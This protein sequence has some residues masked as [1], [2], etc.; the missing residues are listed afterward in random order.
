MFI[1]Y[2][3]LVLALFA[4]HAFSKIAPTHFIRINSDNT[5]TVGWLNKGRCS[6]KLGFL[7]LSAIAHYKYAGGL[8]VTAHYI[9]SA[10]NTSADLLSRGQMP[11][12]LQQQGVKLRINNYTILKLIG[13]PAAIWKSKK[14]LGR[15]PNNVWAVRMSGWCNFTGTTGVAVLQNGPRHVVKEIV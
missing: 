5:N 8:K 7:L 6:K 12:W 4:F 13:N 1:A 14:I 10:H 11:R 15:C 2:R 3:E 9:K